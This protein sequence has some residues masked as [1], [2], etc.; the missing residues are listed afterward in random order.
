MLANMAIIQK[1]SAPQK[2]AI[3]GNGSI[4]AG[5]VNTKETGNVYKKHIICK[6]SHEKQRECM[7]ILN[8]KWP[9]CRNKISLMTLEAIFLA[10]IS[11]FYLLYDK[12]IAILL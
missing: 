2:V 9:A 12:Y 4:N 11:N 6:T 10:D 5:N 1:G 3:N 7:I 8:E